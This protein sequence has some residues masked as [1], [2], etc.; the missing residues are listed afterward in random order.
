M[1]FD[2]EDAVRAFTGGDVEAAIVPREARELLTRFYEV[3][4]HYEVR[5]SMQP[6]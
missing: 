6:V 4:R 2:H 3:A 1:W 5:F